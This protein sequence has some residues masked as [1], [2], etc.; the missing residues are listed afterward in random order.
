MDV[1]IIVDPCMDKFSPSIL[2]CNR[3]NYKTIKD[4]IDK[5]E[6]KYQLKQ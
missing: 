5:S 3:D 6:L 4:A 1:R 2:I